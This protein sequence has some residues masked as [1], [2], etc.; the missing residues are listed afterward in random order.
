MGD[1][2]RYCSGQSQK[3]VLESLNV[4]VLFS[5]QYSYSVFFENQPFTH[6]RRQNWSLSKYWCQWIQKAEVQYWYLSESSMPSP[7][8]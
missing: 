5:L 3:R 7:G 6:L 1:A 2:E 8:K 4:L